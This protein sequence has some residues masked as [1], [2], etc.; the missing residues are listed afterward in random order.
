MFMSFPRFGMFAA[1]I[2]LNKLSP[3][4]L[5]LLLLRLPY[6]H[7]GSNSGAYKSYR[8]SLFLLNC[9][10]ISL[11]DRITSNNMSLNS[12]IISSA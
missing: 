9:F 4:S 7:I 5:S 1:I 10:S 12:L 11:S 3:L 2:S 8:L 6:A